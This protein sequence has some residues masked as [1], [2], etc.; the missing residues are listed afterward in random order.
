[1]D[2]RAFYVAPYLLNVGNSVDINVG[3]IAYLSSTIKCYKHYYTFLVYK[4]T[5]LFMNI[6][7]YL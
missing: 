7:W 2:Y 6:I 1:M 5:M 3:Y 4:L